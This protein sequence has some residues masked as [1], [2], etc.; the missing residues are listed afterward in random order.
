MSGFVGD[1]LVLGS[2]AMTR[3]SRNPGSIAGAI[4]FPLLFFGLFQVVM[5][6]IM[7]AQG[8]DYWQLLP[9]TIVVQAML[10]TGMSSAYYV[11]DD[12]LTGITGRLRSLP[13]NRAAPMMGRAIGDLA[14][15]LVSM[16]VVLIAG[17]L[18]GM[19]FERGI[20]GFLGFVGIALLF[21]IAVSLG[22]G[23]IGYVAK[24]AVGA[25]S[26]ASIP[27]LPLL[28]LSS[29]FA[30]VENFPGW[31]QPVVSRQPVTATIDALRA[32]SGEGD[33][34]GPVIRSILWSVGLAIVFGVLSA[35]AMGRTT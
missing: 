17:L 9:S 10:F 16:T 20:G 35:R 13:I 29:G 4:V 12:K 21:A 34:A 15:A 11:A 27:Y 23:L 8:F 28:M 24:S 7:D 26:I 3:S 1:S 14:R 32:L 2:R 6:R 19:R 30:P 33:L 31:M 18:G 22:M 5:G 25:T